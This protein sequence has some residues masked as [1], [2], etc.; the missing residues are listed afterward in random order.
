MTIALPMMLS[1]QAIVES[2]V[3]FARTS[4]MPSRYA[5]YADAHPLWLLVPPLTFVGYQL[6]S[7]LVLARV[8]EPVMHAVLNALKRTIVIGF[9]ALWML[10][11]IS[12]EYASG[13]AVAII[14]ASTYSVVKA[15][16][17]LSSTMHVRLRASL[18]IIMGLATLAQLGGVSLQKVD[19]SHAHG[20]DPRPSR[21]HPSPP[22]LAAAT[23]PNPRVKPRFSFG[24][25]Q[26]KVHQ[27]Q[28]GHPRHFVD[29]SGGHVSK[30]S[31]THLSSPPPPA[32][33]NDTATPHARPPPSRLR[34]LHNKSHQHQ[35][36]HEHEH[37]HGP[38]TDG[39]A[40]ALPS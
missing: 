14:G 20:L 19:S 36:E 16:P 10:E 21:R 7:I 25:L 32:P 30:R 33:T 1:L 24:H 23:T 22:P 2:V 12:P 31:P 17:Q 3:L 26:S 38:Q 27:T 13:A 5:H 28:H 35:H 34:D 39:R 29:A 8:G 6:S 11:P 4:P 40:K 15:R 37:H 18:V 9:G